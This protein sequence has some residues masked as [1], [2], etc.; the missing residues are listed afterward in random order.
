MAC[1]CWKWN[2]DR[3]SCKLAA[4]DLCYPNRERMSG[5]SE[6]EFGRN[7]EVDEGRS[8]TIRSDIITIIRCWLADV[9]LPLISFHKEVDSWDCERLIH[10]FVFTCSCP[11]HKTTS[12]PSPEDTHSPTH[13]PTHSL[14]RFPLLTSSSLQ[15]NHPKCTPPANLP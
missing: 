15:Y 5:W 12:I 13:S 6:T 11:K 14:T 9:T 2:I 1:L 3:V 4:L 7:P 10:S 8:V